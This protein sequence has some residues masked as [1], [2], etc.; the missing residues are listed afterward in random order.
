M[1]LLGAFYL[2]TG[3]LAAAEPF[4][5]RGLRIN[6]IFDAV[7]QFGVEAARSVFEFAVR[8]RERGVVGIGIGGD[9]QKAP[10]ELFREAYAYAADHG[11][12]SSPEM[13]RRR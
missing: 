6:W 8:Y 12:L 4:Q 3:I 5:F 10:P 7:R 11:L 9:E 1:R 13:Q 2:L